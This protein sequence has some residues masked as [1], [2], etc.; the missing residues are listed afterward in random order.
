VAELT[1]E[2]RTVLK[3]AAF[4]AV[5]LVSNADPGFFAMLKESFAASGSLAGTTGLVKDVLTTGALP[6]LP[7][8]S[9]EEVEAIVL[10]ALARSVA[11]LRE[12]AP[13]EVANYQAAVVGATEQAARAAHGV[14]AR[15]AEMITKVRTALGL[16]PTDE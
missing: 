8:R 3:T 5:F 1:A 14:N 7:R 16:S 4:G 13:D 6:R 10:P 15:E 2:E 12:K 9:P 11:V